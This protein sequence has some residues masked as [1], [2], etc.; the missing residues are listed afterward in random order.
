[1]LQGEDREALA[2]YGCGRPLQEI[3]DLSDDLADGFADFLETMGQRFVCRPC[4]CTEYSPERCPARVQ[5][6]LDAVLGVALVPEDDGDGASEAPDSLAGEEFHCC[7][8]F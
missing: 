6:G 4:L 5:R 8:Y 3:Q 7:L 2:C 1:M